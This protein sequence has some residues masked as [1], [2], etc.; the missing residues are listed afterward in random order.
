[1]IMPCHGIRPVIRY[2]RIEPFVQGRDEFW[3]V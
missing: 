3:I 2:L 1:M